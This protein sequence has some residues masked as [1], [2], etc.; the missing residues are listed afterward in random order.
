LAKDYVEL[1]VVFLEYSVNPDF[2]TRSTRW[3]AAFGG[4]SANTP[5]M[6]VDSGNQF[7]SGWLDDFYNTYKTMVDNSMV[8][9]PQASLEAYAWR[10]G[11]KVS[12][13]LQLQNLAGVALSPSNFATLHGIVYE[14]TEVGITSRYVRAAVSTGISNLAPGASATFTFETAD[15]VGVDWE[16][17]HYLVLVDYIP[18]DSLGAYDMLQAA[19]AVLVPD[20]FEVKPNPLWFLIDPLDPP[21]PSASLSI[22]GAGFTHWSAVESVP[23]LTVSPAN[24][25]YDTHPVVSIDS[26]SL[27]PGLQQGVIGFATT[28]GYFDEYVIVNAYYAPLEQV[29][30]PFINR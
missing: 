4:G 28:D 1:P 17:L 9:L 12:F 8:R 2:P 27:S 21:N 22:Q 6:M 11:N 10:T 16:K 15:L 13:Y 5:L 18:A 14:D 30:L 20:P 19:Q 3:W 25:P 24:G 23:W 26:A 7:T 29:Y